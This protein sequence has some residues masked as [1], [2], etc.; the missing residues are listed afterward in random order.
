MAPP[1][2]PAVDSFD[3]FVERSIGTIEIGD[4]LQT[5]VEAALALVGRDGDP[6]EYHFTLPGQGGPAL[7]FDVTITVH[8]RNPHD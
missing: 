1:M 4:G 5:P 2:K 6:G 7:D 3:V 8:E